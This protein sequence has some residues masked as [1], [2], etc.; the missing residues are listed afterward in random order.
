VIS[1]LYYKEEEGKEKKMMM[2][3][4]MRERN[5][6]MIEVQDLKEMMRRINEDI[7][8][9][10]GMNHVQT[11]KEDIERI[12]EENLRGQD[13]GHHLLRRI[14]GIDI[15][16]LS[17]K[18]GQDLLRRDI[19]IDIDLRMIKRGQSLPRRRIRD[20]DINLLWIS[21]K[22]YRK[23]GERNPKTLIH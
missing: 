20:I 9:S 11:T 4:M 13:H 16:L 12:K 5:Q 6:D 19:D 3:M 14:K 23:E 18:R 7:E 22:D 15:D 1:Q 10:L 17:I 21:K 8:I 2:R